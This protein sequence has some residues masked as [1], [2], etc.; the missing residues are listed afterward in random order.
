VSQN[1]PV[2][3][4]TKN[5]GRNLPGDIFRAWKKF[6]RDRQPH[7]SNDGFATHGIFNHGTVAPARRSAAQKVAWIASGASPARS[8]HPDRSAE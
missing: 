2:R 5:P 7:T 8:A 6:D 1:Q 3:P 4:A